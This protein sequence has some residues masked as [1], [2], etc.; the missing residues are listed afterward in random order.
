MA[1]SN[2]QKLDIR[3]ENLEE[4]QEDVSKL[5]PEHK[6]GDCHFLFLDASSSC[7]G[8]AIAS[9]DYLNKRAKLT[10]AGALWFD[11][12]WDHAEKYDYIYNTIQ[13]YFE[14]A[15]QIDLI[16]LE[17]YSVNTSKGSGI[18]VS[19][20]LQG[21]ILAAAQSNGVKCLRF[22]PQSWRSECGIK[23]LKDENGKKDYKTPAKEF[24]GK[25]I[26]L[27]ETVISNITKKPRSTPSDVF[28]A[29]CLGVGWLK[30]Q[31]IKCT[32]RDVDF[33]SHIGVG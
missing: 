29:M 18:M 13:T 26:T 15:E 22:A 27:P 11:P 9:V 31:G 4:N 17:Q 14:V 25:H 32:I 28:D 12:K 2:K 1:K 23:P 19:S 7:T 20:E 21:T 30:R 16:V 3:V 10:K 24:I 5:V 8:F 6:L 33:E